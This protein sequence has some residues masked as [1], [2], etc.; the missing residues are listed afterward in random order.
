MRS[1]LLLSSLL[2]QNTLAASLHLKEAHD[3]SSTKRSV[4]APILTDLDK[5]Q[6]NTSG[7]AIDSLDDDYD[8]SDEDIFADNGDS[9]PAKYV[10]TTMQ[11]TQILIMN[12]S[13]V[14]SQSNYES[15][16]TANLAFVNSQPGSQTLKTS[17]NEPYVFTGPGDSDSN[18][19]Q[20][21]AANS[22]GTPDITW[23]QLSAAYTAAQAYQKSHGNRN[24]SNFYITDTSSSQ[25]SS[26]GL[27]V[28]GLLDKVKPPVG[29]A[30]PSSPVITIPGS[31]ANANLEI[32]VDT[33]DASSRGS[34]EAELMTEQLLDSRAWANK[35][36]TTYNNSLV[37]TNGQ[38]PWFWNVYNATS[39]KAIF[40]LNLTQVQDVHWSELV[41]TLDALKTG[42]VNKGYYMGGS[43]SVVNKTT[44]QTIMTGSIKGLQ[45]PWRPSGPTSQNVKMTTDS[46]VNNTFVNSKGDAALDHCN[47]FKA[48][49]DLNP[50]PFEQAYDQF[51]ATSVRA[52]H[53]FIAFTQ[54]HFEK[55]T[56]GGG[57]N[58]NKIGAVAGI[59][60]CSEIG[61]TKLCPKGSGLYGN[62]IVPL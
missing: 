3:L 39:D 46:I 48:P 54:F 58:G 62:D 5:R 40:T 55:P 1:F 24:Y 37:K 49:S 44:Q 36:N 35:Y 47:A 28:M 60:P 6:S 61:G 34:I 23:A 53:E 51:N 10:P 57:S 9:I 7:S 16:Q 27:S 31:D 15:A 45:P 22:P 38:S 56:I 18:R 42:M 41:G 2:L 11:N 4:G 32:K 17:S 43:I 14:G 20:I 12:S 26:L 13:E 29:A 33:S 19:V 52:N 21:V 25:P 50:N 59:T 30:T 8:D